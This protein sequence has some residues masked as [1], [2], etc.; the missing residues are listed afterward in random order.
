MVNVLS[1]HMNLYIVVDCKT[2]GCRTAHVLMH[3]GEKSEA[4]AREYRMSYPLTIAC[5]TC[6]GSYDYSDSE[7]RFRQTELPPPPPGHLDLLARP[8]FIENR[9]SGEN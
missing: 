9:M 6:G 4:P 8:P 3:L 1:L 2:D 7:D 5:P